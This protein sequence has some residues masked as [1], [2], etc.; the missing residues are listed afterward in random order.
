MT[1]LLLP[2][3]IV[4]KDLHFDRSIDTNGIVVHGLLWLCISA[5][6]PSIL[7]VYLVLSCWQVR[8][9][10]VAEAYPV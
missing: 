2:V 5:F 3:A 8:E 7:E 6:W 9:V 1:V 10:Y 4:I